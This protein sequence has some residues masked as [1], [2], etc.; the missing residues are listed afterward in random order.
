MILKLDCGLA[1]SDERL[2]RKVVKRT[3]DEQS[4]TAAE[5]LSGRSHLAQRFQ[6]AV[7]S[8]WPEDRQRTRR[9]HSHLTAFRQAKIER[10]RRTEMELKEAKGGAL[11]RRATRRSM[12][13]IENRA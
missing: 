6:R 2:K 13:A 8:S 4:S 1:V 5:H 3:F 7:G 12:A 10:S 11:T 9:S